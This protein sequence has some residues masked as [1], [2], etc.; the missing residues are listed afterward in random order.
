MPRRAVRKV[1]FCGTSSKISSVTRVPFKDL[2]SFSSTPRNRFVSFNRRLTGTEATARRAKIRSM[3]IP[4]NSSLMI[5]TKASGTGVI[6][7][8]ASFGAMRLIIFGRYS[9]KSSRDTCFGT[10]TRVSMSEPRLVVSGM[11]L[12]EVRVY[13]AH[14]AHRPPDD[15]YHR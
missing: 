10:T 5:G 2:K 13:L 12:V 1:V 14:Q 8:M 11:S 9:K 15:S 3:L 7:W 6:S 4:E